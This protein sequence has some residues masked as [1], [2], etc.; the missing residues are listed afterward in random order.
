MPAVYQTSQ[1]LA[2]RTMSFDDVDIFYLANTLSP[3]QLRQEIVSAE[4]QANLSDE[5]H[6]PWTDYSAACREAI[7]WLRESRAKPPPAISHW[8]DAGAI[9][10]QNDIVDIIERYTRLRKAGRN[11]IGCCPIHQDRHPSLTVYPDQQTWHCFGCNQG[12]DIIAFIQAVEHCDFRG[13][14]A[15]LGGS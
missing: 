1:P 15:I 13:A 4:V 12:G 14:A 3:A 8:I 5:D 2:N 7:A 11:L 6:F 10:A 9:K